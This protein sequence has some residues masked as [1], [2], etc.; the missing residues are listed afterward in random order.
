MKK[1]FKYKPG[2]QYVHESPDGGNTVY[3][4]AVN[5]KTG[6]KHLVYRSENRIFEDEVE[7]RSWYVTPE[8]VKLCMKHKGV[9]SA[10]EK[11]IVMLKLAGYT[12]NEYE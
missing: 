3:A 12:F 11:Y 4:R 10:W 2:V 1:R 9:Q 6:T 7:S 5:S 8:A